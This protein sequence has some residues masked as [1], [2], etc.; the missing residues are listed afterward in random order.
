[1]TSNNPEN[2]T[3]FS[4]IEHSQ[5]GAGPIFRLPR[6]MTALE[7]WGFGLSGHLSWFFTIPLIAVALGPNTMLLMLPAV[8]IG[9]LFNFQIRRLGEQWLEMA[10]GT[11][12]YITHLLKRYPHLGRYAAIGY[13]LAWVASAPMNAIILTNLIKANLEPLGITCP[14]SLLKIG[15]TLLPYVL[16]FSGSRAL[17]ILHLFFVLPAVGFSLLFC[18]QGIN[19]LAFSPSSPGLL[20]PLDLKTIT[21]VPFQDWAKWLFFALWLT[22]GCDTAASFV[23]DSRRPEKTLR[24][25]TFAA[26]L[27]PPVFLGTAWVLMRLATDPTGDGDIFQIVLSAAKPFWGKEVSLLVT[28]LLTSCCLLNNATAVSNTPRILHQLSLDG[29]LSPVFAVVSRRGVLSPSLISGLVFS[30]LGLL[31]GDVFRI[32]V[33]TGTGWLASFLIL[34]LGLWLHRRQAEVRSPGV[35]LICCFIYALVLVVGG[36]AWSHTDWLIGLLLPLAVMLAD[37]GVRRI[38]LAPFQPAWWL[39]RDR[40]YT[41]TISHDFVAVQVIVLLVLVCGTASV[42][43]IVKANL[44]GN[45][46]SSNN[47]LFAVWLLTV[48]FV[49]IAIACWTSLPQVAAIDEAR[50]Q[51][52]NLFMTALDT[53][54]DTILVINEE[55]V[56]N[57]TNP[58]AGMLLQA[59]SEEILGQHLGHFLLEFQGTPASWPSNSEQTLWDANSTE[60]ADSLSARMIEATVSHRSNRKQAEYIVI[61]RDITER[62]QAEKTLRRSEATLREQTAQLQTALQEL[63]QAQAQLIQTEKMSS[64]GQLVAGIAHEINNPVNFI[65][66]NL[67]HMQGYSGDLLDFVS[68]YQQRYPESDPEI[69]ARAQALDLEFLRQDIPK[70]LSSMQSGADRIRQIVLSLRNFS[71][72][73]EAEMKP[74]DIHTGIDSTL[75]IL[76]HRLRARPE[77]P[78][79]Q[80]IKN[81]GDLPEVECYAGQ[82]NQVFINILSNAIDALEQRDSQ[83]SFIDIQAAPSLITITTQRQGT[84]QVLV[85]IADNGPGMMAAVRTKIFDPFYTTKPVGQGTGLGLSISYQIITERHQGSLRCTSVPQQGSEFWITIPVKQHTPVIS[86]GLHAKSVGTSY[87]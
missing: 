75:L 25:L 29:L 43:W 23:A 16:A 63:Q 15:F 2:G 82:L 20:P 58:A 14:E 9:M 42:T 55:G 66:G 87:S 32:V 11:P 60:P 38:P 13:W 65:A 17:A 45:A 47:D 84:D 57:Q 70:L 36:S 27:I 77:R 54:P 46:G 37:S 62:K 56:I 4:V 85:K 34:G 33:V 19:W 7:T 86:S 22:T 49:A 40:P 10:G 51:A 3:S 18:W 59:A 52:E 35:W 6:S 83:R 30:L 48:A 31:W 8:V 53:V 78:E 61:L 28:L 80:V 64:L 69:V 41:Y 39:K 44:D 24:F 76:Q 1:M 81:Y 73:D 79:I 72:L 50:K 68:L 26:W 5:S 12:N 71:R 67:T 21:A 74:V